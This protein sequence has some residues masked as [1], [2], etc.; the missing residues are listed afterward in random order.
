MDERSRESRE[1]D[2][3][4]KMKRPISRLR[5]RGVAVEPIGPCSLTLKAVFR[6][7]VLVRG[8]VRVPPAR[9]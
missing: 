3:E 6:R 7:A 8:C 9:R 2:F 1:H 5:L 4:G